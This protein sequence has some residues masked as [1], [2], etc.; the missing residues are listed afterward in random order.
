M[1]STRGWLTMVSVDIDISRTTHD[2][3]KLSRPLYDSCLSRGHDTMKSANC[4]PGR[5][6][7]K[8]HCDEIVT[9]AVGEGG[10]RRW[11]V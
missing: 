3:K 6:R 1:G 5:V 7:G 4:H 11:P 10:C 9:P 2:T 8:Q